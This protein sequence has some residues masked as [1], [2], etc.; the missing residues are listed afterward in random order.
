[1]EY[2]H[3]LEVLADLRS[4]VGDIEH[5]ICELGKGI[6]THDPVGF[7]LYRTREGT[8]LLR[9]LLWNADLITA[10]ERHRVQD[11]KRSLP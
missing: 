6:P 2:E 8:S 10:G 11:D 1:M 4:R 3:I 9:G 5:D 7:A